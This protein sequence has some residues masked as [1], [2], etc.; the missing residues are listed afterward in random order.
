V[1]A[2]DD[3]AQR[4]AAQRARDR[5]ERRQRE[6]RTE[7]RVA[8]RQRVFVVGRRVVLTAAV[9]LLAGFAVVK[10][11]DALRPGPRQLGA[12]TPIPTYRIVYRVEFQPGNVVRQEE[13]LVERPFHSIYRSTLNGKT[14]LGQLS[15]DRGLYFF[16]PSRGWYQITPGQQRATND[17]QPA[18]SVRQAIRHHLA[19]VIGTE[20]ILG[21][22]CT[23]VRT[24]SSLGEVMKAPTSGTHVELCLDRTGVILRYQ[25]TLNGHIV[26]KMDATEF[27]PNAAIPAGTFEPTPI[28]DANQLVRS[29]ALTDAARAKLNPQLNPA[30]GMRYATGIT[31][32][33]PL[34]TSLNV[35]TVELYRSGAFDCIE[36]DYE[37]GAQSNQGLAV[38]LGGGHTGHLELQLDSSVLKVPSGSNTLLIRG[39]D[40]DQIVAL[41]KRLVYH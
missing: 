24:G 23:T 7:R 26:E 16:D 25:S 13:H 1:P 2:R 6:Q 12:V 19:S 38:D 11:I 36:L 20:T 27:E 8:R 40:P 10:V 22:P 15:N 21:R 37:E 33:E 29:A 3:R 14:D 39:T 18:L 32:V 4:R 31:R 41:G 17:P 28:S 35:T 34:G 9:V 30:A 5:A